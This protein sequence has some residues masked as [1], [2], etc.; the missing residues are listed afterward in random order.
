M[1][2]DEVAKARQAGQKASAQQLL[3]NPQNAVLKQKEEVRI[4]EDVLFMCFVWFS[5]L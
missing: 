1:T 5:Y 3:P 4:S 2:A